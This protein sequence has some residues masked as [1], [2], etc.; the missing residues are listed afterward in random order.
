MKRTAG[1]VPGMVGTSRRE[2]T[3]PS[4]A[5]ATVASRLSPGPGELPLNSAVEASAANAAAIP[6]SM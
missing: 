4:S 1:N 5:A 6:L 3:T 2:N